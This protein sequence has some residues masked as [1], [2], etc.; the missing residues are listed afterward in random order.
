VITQ[1]REGNEFNTGKISASG[2][3]ENKIKTI[4]QSNRVNAAV[5]PTHA[6]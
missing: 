6:L 2:G 4:S 3:T 1:K 5:K